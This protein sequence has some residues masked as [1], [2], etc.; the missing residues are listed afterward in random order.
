M[1]RTVC[2][3]TLPDEPAGDYRATVRRGDGPAVATAKIDPGDRG[4][5]C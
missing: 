1:E 3:A 2:T 4:G 5:P